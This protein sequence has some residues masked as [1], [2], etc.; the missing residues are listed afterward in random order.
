MRGWLAP[1]MKRSSTPEPPGPERPI[2]PPLAVQK[3]NVFP[4]A[5]GV[6]QPA[7]ATA[8]AATASQRAITTALL[9]RGPIATLSRPGVL[10]I[11]AVSSS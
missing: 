1:V 2:L 10:L 7:A 4:C 11:L 3:T 5:A 8:T 9:T 6:A